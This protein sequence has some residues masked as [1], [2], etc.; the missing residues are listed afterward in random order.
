MNK[1]YCLPIKKYV[2]LLYNFPKVRLISAKTGVVL[3][4]ITVSYSSK[5]RNCAFVNTQSYPW[6]PD[7]LKEKLLAS[8]TGRSLVMN[9]YTYPEFQFKKEE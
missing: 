4:C 8:P 6:A 3:G 2:C 9:D 7:W 1:Y 5:H